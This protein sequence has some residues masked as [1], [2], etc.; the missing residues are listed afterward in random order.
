MTQ[1]QEGQFVVGKRGHLGLAKVVGVAADVAQIEFFY[2]TARQED[3]DVAI[4]DLRRVRPEPGTRC[5]MR[6]NSAWTMGRIARWD[7][8]HLEFR[9]PDFAGWVRE[10]DVYVRNGGSREDPLNVL[11]MHGQ[12]TPLFHTGRSRFIAELIRQR[13]VSRGLTGALSAGI[14]LYEHQIAAALRVLTDPVQRYLLADEVG[15][16][17]TIEAG[18]V[19]RQFLLDEIDGNALILT[20]DSLVGQWR[21]ELNSKF[22]I[23]EHAD[24]VKILPYRE[25]AET[26]PPA[27]LIV[28][29]AHRVAAGIDSPSKDERQL[30]D[31]IAQ[32]AHGTTQV[33]LL[34]A[35]PLLHLERDY[36]AMLH[37]L[38]PVAHP[39]DSFDVFTDRLRDRREIGQIMLT[40]Q[41][42]APPVVLELAASQLAAICPEDGHLDELCRNLKLAAERE[43]PVDIEQCLTAVR[44]HVSEAHRLHRRMIRH[45]R[46]DIEHSMIRARL[47]RLSNEHSEDSDLDEY[48]RVAEFDPDE[49]T[50]SLVDALEQWRE[51]AQ[52][53]CLS[54]NTETYDRTLDTYVALLE[55]ASCGEQAILDFSAARQSKRASCELE[56]FLGPALVASVMGVDPIDGEKEILEHATNCRTSDAR[57]GLA[58]QVIKQMLRRQNRLG[59]AEKV[60]VFAGFGPL[61][62]KTGV[63]LRA[64]L[65]EA[66]VAELHTGMSI[67]ECGDQVNHFRTESECKVIVCDRSGEEGHN[68]QA[69]VCVV[70]VDVPWS[71]GR[72]EQRMGR[73]DR[74]GQEEEL[75]IKILVGAEDGPIDVWARVL[76][77]GFGVFHQSIASAQLFAEGE[78]RRLAGLLFQNGLSSLSHEIEAVRNGLREELQ[79]VEEQSILDR[80]DTSAYAEDFADLE[81]DIGRTAE[82]RKAT[83][84][85]VCTTLRA[86]PERKQPEIVKYD[87]LRALVPDSVKIQCQFGGSRDL[88]YSRRTASQPTYPRLLRLGDP[89][90]EALYKE[91]IVD[92]RGQVFAMWR[93]WP[94]WSP[95]PGKEWL[96]FRFDFI[97]EADIDTVMASLDGSAKSRNAIQRILDG[98]L[99]PRIVSVLVDEEGAPLMDDTLRETLMRGYK[100]VSDGGSDIN[101]DVE[102]I[103]ILDTVVGAA[104]WPLVCQDARLKAEQLVSEE[105]TLRD[106]SERSF[107]QA[108]RFHAERL[109]AIRVRAT[110]NT[111]TRTDLQLEEQLSKLIPPAVRTPEIRLDSVGFF[112]VSGRLPEGWRVDE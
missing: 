86:R 11:I 40:I 14:D 72:V 84:G 10:S 51:A 28:D 30:Y 27:F 78:S 49:E 62:R 26:S 98:L 112:V 100:K 1:L 73:C 29:E 70:H 22:R 34:S 35:T 24:R 15:L 80:Q 91:L 87:F 59:R 93:R 39:L 95:E 20:P 12:E 65:G 25:L 102:R 109:A 3:R 5:Y 44:A 21:D 99:P 66:A 18:I 2:S 111:A 54:A 94:A 19:L 92:D 106:E 6:H 108:I 67:D 58:A 46:V 90:V 76:V 79:R 110:N 85:W 55:C 104:R 31:H 105:P 53:T 38:D 107:S 45:R 52:A 82:I 63:L 83:E 43:D 4:E 89:L 61:V 68:F 23:D 13:A 56:A 74:I 71:P 64:A 9:G 69:G 36:W 50:Y 41:E 48:S 42:D 47:D 60:V 101:L 17:K 77:N 16:G 32:L 96:G 37:M 8:D 97:I 81:G 75:R 57:S 88:T 7:C 33:L 103:H